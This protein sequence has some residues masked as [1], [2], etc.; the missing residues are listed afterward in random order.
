MWKSLSNYGCMHSFHTVIYNIVNNLLKKFQK[1][2][3]K[4]A[5]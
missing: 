2:A 4:T 5:Q 1:K 3:S